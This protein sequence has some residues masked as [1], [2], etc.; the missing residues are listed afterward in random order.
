[1]HYRDVLIAV[2]LVPGVRYWSGCQRPSQPFIDTLAMARKTKALCMGG[3]MHAY[4]ITNPQVF[5]KRENKLGEMYQ[6]I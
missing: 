1:M 4:I 5:R 6:H 3:K 2:G